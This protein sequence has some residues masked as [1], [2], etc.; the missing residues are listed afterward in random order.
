MLKVV[1][2][3]L[4][5]WLIWKRTGLDFMILIVCSLLCLQPRK[6]LT[7]R[8]TASSLGNRLRSPIWPGN[9]GSSVCVLQGLEFR[10]KGRSG[11]DYWL[12]AV[13]PYLEYDQN[14]SKDT[15]LSGASILLSV[16]RKICTYLCHSVT[17]EDSI[18][19]KRLFIHILLD[20]E[21]EWEIAFLFILHYLDCLLARNEYIMPL[22]QPWI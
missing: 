21:W 5:L 17:I 4:K 2:F 3:H 1:Q 14:V 15:Q 10:S 7:K 6:I 18:Q 13:C 9:K 12:L 19:V 16:Q 22:I 20:R 8:S 11:V